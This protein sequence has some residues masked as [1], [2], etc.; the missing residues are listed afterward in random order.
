LNVKIDRTFSLTQAAEA[1]SYVEEK[2]GD[3]FGKVVLLNDE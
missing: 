2:K 1:H 3:R